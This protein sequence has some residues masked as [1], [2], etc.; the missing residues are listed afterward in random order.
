MATA[1]APARKRSGGFSSAAI[2][3]NVETGKVVAY[4]GN[5]SEKENIHG[6]HVDVITAPRS[7]GSILK[8][9]LYALYFI[10]T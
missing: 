10:S 2:V 7:T 9:F 4:I 8:P 6:N 5:T 3:I 1:S